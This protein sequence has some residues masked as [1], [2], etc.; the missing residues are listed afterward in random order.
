MNNVANGATQSA[1]QLVPL[2]S[3]VE[4][5][6]MD[7][8]SS[9]SNIRADTANQTAQIDDSVEPSRSTNPMDRLDQ[10]VTNL[11]ENIPNS[12]RQSLLL[13]YR[14]DFDPLEYLDPSLV[15]RLLAE[16]EVM[17][18]MRDRQVLNQ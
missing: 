6:Q 12:I 13:D 16:R 11:L 14:L 4:T 8:E 7:I 10:F 17:I 1:D 9:T 2:G 15:E 5:V 3:S 18:T